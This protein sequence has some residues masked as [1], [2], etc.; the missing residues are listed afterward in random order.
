M[1]GLHDQLVAGLQQGSVTTIVLAYLGGVLTSA[2]PCVYPM[3]PITIGVIGSHASSSRLHSFLLS[4]VYASGLALVYGGLGVFAAAGGH[5]FGDVSTNPIGYFL[6]ANLC[7]FF[8]AWMMDWIQ[9]PP[10]GLHLSAASNDRPHGGISKWLYTFLM[11]TVSGLVAAPCTAPVLA[12]LLT[13][14]ATT[15]NI[16]YGGSL[17]FVFAFGLS[18]LLIAIGTFTGLATSLP[19]SGVWMAWIKKGLALVMLGAGEYFLIQMGTLMF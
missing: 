3:I 18:T 7:L 11:G 15:G 13:Y 2:T 10:F 4:L 12:T 14:V 16:V 19:R 17:L 1:D 9:L 6:V 5:F 8:G